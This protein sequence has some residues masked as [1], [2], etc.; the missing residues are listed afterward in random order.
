MQEEE[1]EVKPANDEKLNSRLTNL[2]YK[3][4]EESRRAFN[5]AFI[6]E[7]SFQCLSCVRERGLAQSCLFGI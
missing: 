6:Q 3:E 7:L 4:E 1:E 5:Y 2:Y